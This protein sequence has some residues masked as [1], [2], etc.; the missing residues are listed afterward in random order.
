[1]L[2]SPACLERE[3]G[4]RP[5]TIVVVHEH[6]GVLEL[7]EA[8]LRDRGAHVLATHDP[9]EALETIR[10]LKID[11]DAAKAKRHAPRSDGLSST[12]ARARSASGR[13]RSSSS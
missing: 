13:T 3:P 11:L 1:M 7:I 2:V 10:R 8:D 12:E 6:A 5:P 9:F 4:G